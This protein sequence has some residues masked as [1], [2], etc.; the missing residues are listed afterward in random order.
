MLHGVE[1]FSDAYWVI[2]HRFED[3]VA[4]G[5]HDHLLISSLEVVPCSATTRH[6]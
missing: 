6:A 4:R 2:V 5:D 1:P 3:A